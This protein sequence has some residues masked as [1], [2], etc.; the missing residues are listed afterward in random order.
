MSKIKDLR[1]NQDTYVT[2]GNGK[3]ALAVTVD[4]GISIDNPPINKWGVNN[5]IDQLDASAGQAI[6]P[7][8][9]TDQQYIFI[10]SPVTGLNIRSSSAV[11]TN[12]SGLG[13]R[14]VKIIYQ[15][16][17]GLQQSITKEL[18][19]ASPVSL[20]I[21]S[22]GI[23][24]MNVE[25]TGDN[26]INVGTISVQDGSSNIYATIEPGEGQ[27]QI[28]VQR[29]PDNMRGLCK[30]HRCEYVGVNPNSTA[31]MRLR[32][33]KVDGTVLTKWEPEL[34]PTK[35][36][37]EKNYLVGGID[38][39][40]GEWIYWEC[41]DAGTDNLKIRGSFDLEFIEIDS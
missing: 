19:G 15:D 40:P 6:W 13:A 31:S 37:D 20:E 7:I 35:N 34:T 30:Y 28:A 29:I 3:T 27:T 9:A 41:V 33:K 10:D 14:S 25:T 36:E 5:D 12:A 1:G 16:E 39:Q 4:A 26:N 24:R 38:V 17:N 11:D 18:S 2:L 21:S 8:K 23:F 32:V 22:L